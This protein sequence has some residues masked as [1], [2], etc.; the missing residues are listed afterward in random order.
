MNEEHQARLLE[1]FIAAC[2]RNPDAQVP[3]G[4]DPQLAETVRRMLH[5]SPAQPAPDAMKDRVWTRALS[6]AKV[7]PQ[8]PYN[9]S[10]TLDALPLNSEPLASTAPKVVPL[11]IERQRPQPARR[12]LPS[13]LTLA[14]TLSLVVIAIAVLARFNLMDEYGSFQVETATP[15]STHTATPSPMPNLSSTMTPS[16]VPSLPFTATPIP[17]DGSLPTCATATIVPTV[18]PPDWPTMTPTR[19]QERP[20]EDGQLILVDCTP[21][22]IEDNSRG[23]PITTFVPTIVPPDTGS[24]GTITSTPFPVETFMGT[25]TPIPTPRP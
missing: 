18:P 6:A 20:P 13:I 11:P 21:T 5:T 24:D 9:G 23:T 22:P 4:L 8:A 10:G 15:T 1:Q 7:T 12:T 25:A 2:R 14:A 19:A 16:L 3:E 17:M